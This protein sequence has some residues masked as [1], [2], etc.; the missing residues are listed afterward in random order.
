MSMRNK[1][2]VCFIITAF[3]LCTVQCSFFSATMAYA[4]EKACPAMPSSNDAGSSDNKDIDQGYGCSYEFV[5]TDIKNRHSDFY[6]EISNIISS[7]S[8]M[9]SYLSHTH[10]YINPHFLTYKEPPTVISAHNNLI[11]TSIAIHAPPLS[12]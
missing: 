4:S 10:S 9:A 12:I 2:L 8:S 6:Q 11:T 3:I 5:L 1:K 7:F